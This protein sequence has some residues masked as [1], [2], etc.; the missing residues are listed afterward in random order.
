MSERKWNRLAFSR[1]TDEKR[2]DAL[3]VKDGS[4]A[5]VFAAVT[6]VPGVEDML[7]KS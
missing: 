1:R 4:D 5:A 7:W 2:T 3:G 6:P